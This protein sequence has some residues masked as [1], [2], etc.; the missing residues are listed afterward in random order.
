MT[1]PST[2]HLPLTWWTLNGYDLMMRNSVTNHGPSGPASDSRWAMM[3]AATPSQRPG[4]AGNPI[5]TRSARFSS[6]SSLAATR[7]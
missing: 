1:R 7:L 4:L 3:R 6:I 5:A 2:G